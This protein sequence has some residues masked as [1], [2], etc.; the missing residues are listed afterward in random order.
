MMFDVPLCSLK[1]KKMAFLEFQKARKMGKKIFFLK[2][3][4]FSWPNH[5]ETFL[6]NKKG[7]FN[8]FLSKILAQWAKISEKWS[9]IA[10]F[11]WLQRGAHW[12]VGGCLKLFVVL[13]MHTSICHTWILPKQGGFMNDQKSGIFS[14]SERVW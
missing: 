13:F 1:V 8:S 14:H 3:R 11:W 9:K 12:V 2:L 10:Y 6:V 5:L 7:K 4:Y